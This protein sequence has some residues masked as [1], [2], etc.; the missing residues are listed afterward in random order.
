MDVEV[1]SDRRLEGKAGGNASKTQ[2]E[3]P[4]VAEELRNF[5]SM[6]EKW[7]KNYSIWEQVN[8]HNPNTMYVE[9]YR[10]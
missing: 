3:E 5:D 4:N 2:Q 8:R 10:R 6:F 7:E 1:V 9:G